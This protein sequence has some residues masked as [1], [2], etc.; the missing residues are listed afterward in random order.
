MAD[1]VAGTL[2]TRNY[3]SFRGV[4]FSNRKDEISIYRSPDAL[5]MWKNYKNDGGRCIETRPDLE[6]LVEYPDKIHGLF[7][8]NGN[9]IVHSGTKLYKNNEIIYSE[10]AEN[11]SNFFIFNNLLYIKDGNK[12]LV[13]DDKEV[14]EVGGYIPRTSISRSPSGGGTTY[15]D[16]NLLTGIR[17]NSFCADGEATE[18]F[19]DVQDIDADYQVKITINDEEVTSFTVDYEAGKITFNTAPDEPLTTGQD[20]VFIEFRKTVEGYRERIEKCTLLEVFDNRVFFSGNPDYPNILWHCSLEDPTYCSDLDYY[21]EGEDDSKVKS[22]VAGNNAL[23][24][25]KEPSQSNTTLFYHNP[26]IDADY[27]K[28]YP[29][30][31]SSISTG[32]MSHGINFQDTICFFSDRGLESV[33]G[34]VTTEQVLIHRST[35]IDNKLLTNNEYKNLIVEEWEGYLLV[36]LG[37][38]VFL[39]DSRSL[40]TVNNHNEFEWF[41]WKFDKKVTSTCVKDEVLYLCVDEIVKENG[42]NV[43]KHKVYTLT[44]L[45]ETREVEAYWTT[46]QDEFTYPQYQKTTNKKGCV[47]DMEGEEITIYA[48]T[49]HNEFE[50]IDTYKNVKGYVVPRIKKKKWKSIQL[51]FKSSKPFQLYSSTLES[52]VGAYVKR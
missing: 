22:I 35:L 26:T 32:C 14:K 48:K 39:A 49:D 40:A 42:V 1:T 4:D 2:I 28:I 24:V 37:D 43:V 6:F 51:K 13:Y 15:E 17:K 8:Y 44:N 10:M 38:K 27:G 19:L 5:N 31:H 12:Y 3:S 21:T 30:I 25:M 18:Y 46:L 34:D 29:S 36:F 11:K 20:N 7:F 41:Y 52:F 23:W 33:S 50:K 45:S 16:V 47:A 9:R